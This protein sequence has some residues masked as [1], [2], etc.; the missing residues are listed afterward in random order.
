[1]STA[2]FVSTAVFGSTTGRKPQGKTG[3]GVSAAESLPAT[4][5]GVNF[6][7]KTGQGVSAAKIPP[8]GHQDTKEAE[9][10]G[11]STRRRQND[12]EAGAQD[13]SGSSAGGATN[14]FSNKDSYNMAHAR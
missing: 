2:L 9:A 13:V 4:T 1:M 8:Q 14:R 5:A 7:A 11:V 3:Q 6:Q 12:K 10:H